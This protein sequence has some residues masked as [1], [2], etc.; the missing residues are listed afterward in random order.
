MAERRREPKERRSWL[1]VN[2]DALFWL[3]A[4]WMSLSVVTRL[5]GG[6]TSRSAAISILVGL[7]P[8]GVGFWLM[9]RERRGP[10]DE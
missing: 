7:A 8:A 4:I 9:L 6:A 3:G 10:R 2:G 5:C 1:W